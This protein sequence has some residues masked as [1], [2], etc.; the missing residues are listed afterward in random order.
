MCHNCEKKSHLSGHSSCHLSLVL[1][2]REHLCSPISKPPPGWNLR[3]RFAGLGGQGRGLASLSV[4][5]PCCQGVPLLIVQAGL[6]LPSC[7]H[8]R[9]TTRGLVGVPPANRWGKECHLLTPCT[10]VTEVGWTRL[11]PGPGPGRSLGPGWP[12]PQPLS[13]TLALSSLPKVL[14]TPRVTVQTSDPKSPQDVQ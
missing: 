14:G 8:H 6:S 3:E 11:G 7:G 2:T 10:W 9:R 13:K 1:R 12:L 5:S 4:L